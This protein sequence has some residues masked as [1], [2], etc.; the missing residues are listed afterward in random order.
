MVKLGANTDLAQAKPTPF[1]GYDD[2]VRVLDIANNTL[3]SP[4][5]LCYIGGFALDLENSVSENLSKQVSNKAV[6]SGYQISESVIE[7]LATISVTGIIANHTFGI[8]KNAADQFGNIVGNMGKR[9]KMLGGFFLDSLFPSQMK[10]INTAVTKT[11]NAA[12]IVSDKIELIKSFANGTN[13]IISGGSTITR[14]QKQQAMLKALYKSNTP[15]EFACEF[16][17]YPAMLITSMSISRNGVENGA[18]AVSLTLQEFVGVEI[19]VADL[20]NAQFAKNLCRNS[21]QNLTGENVGEQKIDTT[22]TSLYDYLPKELFQ[23]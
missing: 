21:I 16:A 1:K 18:F 5:K 6:E 20:D 12:N 10:A 8:P 14:S 13:E 7:N 22:Q 4:K 3:I 11:Q 15:V 9:L 17:Y 2:V 19:E 23:E